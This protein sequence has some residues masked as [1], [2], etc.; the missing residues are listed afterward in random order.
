MIKIPIAPIRNA[1]IDALKASVDRVHQEKRLGATSLGIHF[2]FRFGR[3]WLALN[4]DDDATYRCPYFEDFQQ[5]NW[6]FQLLGDLVGLEDRVYDQDPETEEPPLMLVDVKESIPLCIIEDVCSQ[7]YPRSVQWVQ[8]WFGDQ[9]GGAWKPIWLLLG[10]QTFGYEDR[11]LLD[12]CRPLPLAISEPYNLPFGDT[13]PPKAG[14]KVFV[15]SSSRDR[16]Y[17]GLYPTKRINAGR[18]FVGH[19]VLNEFDQPTRVKLEPEGVRRGDLAKFEGTI[20]Y[21]D[22]GDNATFISSHFDAEPAVERIALFDG[23]QRWTAVNPLYPVSV[24]DHSRC[25]F[26]INPPE[27]AAL[28]VDIAEFD[29]KALR[30][31]RQSVFKLIEHP[32]LG[33][34]FLEDGH[35]PGFVSLCQKH[36][37]RG[38]KFDM[39]WCE[40]LSEIIPMFEEFIELLRYRLKRLTGSA[41]LK[42]WHN[43]EC[44]YRVHTDFWRIWEFRER[45][46]KDGAEAALKHVPG[47]SSLIRPLTPY[48]STSE[49]VDAQKPV[50]KES[51]LEIERILGGKEILEE[52]R[53]RLCRYLYGALSSLKEM[54]T[55]NTGHL[56]VY[57]PSA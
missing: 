27:G 18:L 55:N 14:L 48:V 4:E 37:L 32:H 43:V 28:D 12:K 9:P 31:C 52:V 29:S 11:I 54:E 15:L 19:P 33:P 53:G 26:G 13:R 22:Q 57:G 25:Q 38:V 16:K 56:A 40:D 24:I 6:G 42:H 8:Q 21:R 7:L 49:F 46:N 51:I 10:E 23:D 20:A 44:L 3:M 50:S 2:D 45:F 5:L 41:L 17:A 39:I 47:I 1:I 30:E 34:F 35:S 36:Q